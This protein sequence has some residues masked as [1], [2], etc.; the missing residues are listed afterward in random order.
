VLWIEEKKRKK[1]TWILE[2]SEEKIKKNRMSI[3]A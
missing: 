2:T 1:K 3:V